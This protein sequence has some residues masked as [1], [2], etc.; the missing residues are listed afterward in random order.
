MM[1]SQLLQGYATVATATDVNVQAITDDS[2]RVAAGTLFVACRGYGQQ[3]AAAFLEQALANGAV[4]MIWDGVEDGWAGV[5]GLPVELP[6]GFACIAVDGLALQQGA[7]AARFYGHPSRSMWLSAVTGTDGKTSVSWM[8]ASVLRNITSTGLLG[9]T[10]NGLFGDLTPSTHTTLPALAFQQ[11]LSKLQSAGAQA[12]SLEVSS[13]ALDQGRIAGAEL[14]C[15]IFTCMARDHL[16]YHGSEA[17]Y[18]AAKQKLFT[19][20]QSKVAV[21]NADDAW[22]NT[23]L[24][25]A[26]RAERT[27]EYGRTAAGSEYIRLANVRLVANGLALS[28]ES[29]LGNAELE[30]PLIGAINAYN[31][32]AVL[33]ALIAY[34]LQWREALS[35]LPAITAPPGRMEPFTK[36][37]GPT[38][39]VDYSHTPGALALA[40]KTLRDYCSQQRSAKLIVVFGCGG[41]RDQGKRA[42]MAQ[43]AEQNADT[44]IVTNDNPRSEDPQKI[45][46]DIH[47]GFERPQQ[48]IPDRAT[49]IRAAIEMASEHDWVLIA[50]KGHEDYQLIGEQRLHFSDREQVEEALNA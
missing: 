36:Q 10:G 41:D 22:A 19:D 11:Q 14:D 3:H 47:A 42:L 7:I 50:G 35:A 25:A 26:S 48:V 5:L 9:T 43:A 44:V 1:L 33:A 32:A 30:L 8:L 29:H 28:I 46:D 38:V 27:I 6:S 39:V 15:A 34:G 20:Y 18:R 13:H 16:D 37:G 2:R 49:A 24:K 40:L 17:N 21:L 12:V 45:I 4:A 31:V 23:E